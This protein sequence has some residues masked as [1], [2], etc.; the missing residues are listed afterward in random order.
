MNSTSDPIEW[1]N[2]AEE[3]YQLARV[4]LQRKLPLTYVRLFMLNSAPKN[5]Q[6]PC[7]PYDKLLFHAPMI[8]RRY[9]LYANRMESYSL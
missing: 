5:A 4:S 1:V 2:R 3:D 9:M 6:K 7:L 8:W